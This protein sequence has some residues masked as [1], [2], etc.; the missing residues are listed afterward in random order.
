MQLIIIFSTM[1]TTNVIV[2]LHCHFFHEFVGT[3]II[4][5]MYNIY[6]C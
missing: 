3:K 2:T 1:G 5:T 4:H 6:V